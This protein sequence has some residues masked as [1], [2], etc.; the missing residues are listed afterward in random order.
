DRI[1]RPEETDKLSLIAPEATI[2]IIR[3]YKVSGKNKVTIP[4]DIT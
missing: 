4:N 3:D 1:L 2:N